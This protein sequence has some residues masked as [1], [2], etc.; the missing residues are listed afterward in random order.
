MAVVGG[1]ADGR[2]IIH[3]ETES[4]GHMG[5]KSGGRCQWSESVGIPPVQDVTVIVTGSICS[6]TGKG[7]DQGR[8]FDSAKAGSTARKALVRQI[9]QKPGETR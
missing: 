2:R 8:P 5:T 7:D 6:C 4:R 3:M 1:K 9:T